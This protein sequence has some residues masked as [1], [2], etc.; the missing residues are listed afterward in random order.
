MRPYL[1]RIRLTS[2]LYSS[3][4]LRH[5]RPCSNTTWEKD[6]HRTIKQHNYIFK[7]KT[8]LFYNDYE[9][10]TYNLY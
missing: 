7:I 2:S 8:I 3:T 10:S 4:N 9:T 6:E 1:E 5:G